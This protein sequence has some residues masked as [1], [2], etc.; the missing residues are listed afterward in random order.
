MAE[1]AEIKEELNSEGIK[2]FVDGGDKT[3]EFDSLTEILTN[4][5]EKPVDPRWIK[6]N[7]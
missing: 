3:E 6:G 1:L 7:W 4:C 5:S 2:V